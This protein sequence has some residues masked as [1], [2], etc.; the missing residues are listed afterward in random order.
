M[1]T[2]WPIACV[3]GAYA[4]VQPGGALCAPWRSCDPAQYRAGRVRG[5][6]RDGLCQLDDHV[7]VATLTYIDNPTSAEEAQNC[8]LNRLLPAAP[9]SPIV[10]D[11]RLRGRWLHGVSTQAEARTQVHLIHHQVRI[12]KPPSGGFF[13]VRVSIRVDCRIGSS[14]DKWPSLASTKRDFCSMN[15]GDIRGPK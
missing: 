12:G 6:H 8:I 14:A 3:V 7:S 13:F 15:A 5:A 2:S 4:L 10:Y 1:S 9:T 11:P